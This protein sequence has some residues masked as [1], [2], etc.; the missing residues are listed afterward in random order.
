MS[1]LQNN[2]IVLAAILISLA[3]S[4]LC[5]DALPSRIPVHWGIDGRI[6]KH[7]PKQIGAYLY[8]G[9]MVLIF[10][11]FR[12]IPY[13][14]RGRVRQL[15]EIGLYDPLRNG[16]VY[17]FFYSHTQALGIGLDLISPHANFILGSLSLVCLLAGNHLR[18]THPDAFLALLPRLGLSQTALN[19][20]CTSLVASGALG[21]I[22]TATNVLQAAWLTLP[23]LFTYLLARRRF[24]SKEKSTP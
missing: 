3:A 19:S 8:P 18:T 5:Y 22:G 13:A 20:V 9:A 23:L 4:Y 21:L 16:A 7:M 6:D 1:L 17:L 10:T 2:R 12:L 24:P 11:F 15:R 14:D